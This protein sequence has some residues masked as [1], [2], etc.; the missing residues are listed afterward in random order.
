MGVLSF[1]FAL[2]FSQ[3]RKIFG[4]TETYYRDTE[5]MVWSNSYIGLVK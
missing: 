4:I 5:E 1:P 3:Y 2:F